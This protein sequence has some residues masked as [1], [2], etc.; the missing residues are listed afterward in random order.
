MSKEHLKGYLLIS[1]GEL[2]NFVTLGLIRHPDQ[3]ENFTFHQ[4]SA[5]SRPTYPV[6]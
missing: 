5:L 6:R 1:I 3:N 4:I 2:F